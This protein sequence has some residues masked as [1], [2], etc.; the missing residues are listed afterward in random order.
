ML[1]LFPTGNKTLVF[2]AEGMRR[3]IKR[4]SGKGACD[5]RIK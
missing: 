2:L 5:Y 3:K 1:L 4:K